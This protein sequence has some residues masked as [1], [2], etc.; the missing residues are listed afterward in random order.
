MVFYSYNMKFSKY[1]YL[2]Q[3]VPGVFLTSY[4]TSCNLELL[5]QNGITHVVNA[6][7]RQDPYPSEFTYLHLDVEDEEEE[8]IARYFTKT[9]RFITNAL[10]KGGR[11]VVNC[12]MG[13]SRSAT[14]VLAFLVQ[15]R[16]F[17]L[18]EAM[19]S[20]KTIRPV[21]CPND[22][23]MSQLRDRFNISPM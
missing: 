10:Q 13:I 21:I 9:S 22:G 12:M 19:Q 6:S 23:F 14:L 17:S 15:K 3:I 5:R 1:D 8:D 11:V 16:H 4:R 20:V 2:N 7:Q 18:S